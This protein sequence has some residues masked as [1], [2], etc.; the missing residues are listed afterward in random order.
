MERMEGRGSGDD[1]LR[2]EL[3]EPGRDLG[4]GLELEDCPWEEVDVPQTEEGC[5]PL[6]TACQRGMTEV[7]SSFR[8]EID[9]VGWVLCSLLHSQNETP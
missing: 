1:M 8:E 4:L 9:L 3:E 5:T 6:I 7:N 2:A